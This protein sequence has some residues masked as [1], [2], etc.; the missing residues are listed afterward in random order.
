MLLPRGFRWLSTRAGR[1]NPVKGERARQRIREIDARKAGRVAPLADGGS[2]DSPH[3][4]MRLGSLCATAGIAEL[5]ED[6]EGRRCFILQSGEE[7]T[8]R[9]AELWV[10]PPN[11]LGRF[12]A[13]LLGAAGFGPTLQGCKAHDSLPLSTAA[14]LV[15]HALDALR[16]PGDVH[17]V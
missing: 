10:L 1:A 9:L 14:P 6:A 12:D 7:P 17:E 16:T 13:G 11:A 2:L 15:A 8:A 4:R 5:H 3:D